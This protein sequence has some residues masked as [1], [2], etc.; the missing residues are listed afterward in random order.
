ML[1]SRDLGSSDLWLR[2]LERSRRRRV[3]AVEGRKQSTRRKGGSVAMSAAL[4][5]GPGSSILAATAVA[6]P[7]KGSKA[8]SSPRVKRAMARV[9]LEYGSSGEAVAA[10]Q[11]S[12]GIPADGIFGP[13]TQGAV[14]SFQDDND[15]RASGRVDERTWETLLDYERLE[16]YRPPA[17]K[18]ANTGAVDRSPAA[19]PVVAID[20]DTSETD[21]PK[22]S[23]RV[24]EAPPKG[25]SPAPTPER[26]DPSEKPKPS[27]EEAPKRPDADAE[28]RAD[29]EAEKRAKAEA[30]EK[31]A[32]AEAEKRDRADTPKRRD[33]ADR[34]GT[35]VEGSCGGTLAKPVSGPQTS[36]FGQR[37]GRLH[38][39]IDIAAPSGT[40]IKSAACGVV[41]QAGVA[42]GYGNMVCVRHTSTFTT[43]YAHMSRIG[44]RLGAFVRIGEVIGYVGST[45]NSTGPHLHFETRVSG[46]PRNPIAYLRG[47]QMTPGKPVQMS[48]RSGRALSV[49]GSRTTPARVTRWRKAS[50]SYAAQRSQAA[51]G[52]RA[53][54]APRST[55]PKR[56]GWTASASR[57]STYSSGTTGQSSTAPQADTS[58]EETTQTQTPVEQSSPSVSSPSG[59]G[60]GSSDGTATT[61]SSPSPAGPVVTPDA[62]AA[63]SGVD[64][65]STSDDATGGSAASGGAASSDT[66]ASTGESADAAESPASSGSS[67]SAGSSGSTES[68]T[69][70]SGS[71]GSTGS[72]ES[73]GST[74][75]TGSTGTSGST[76]S[77]ESSGSSGS[78]GATE[79]PDSTGSG[80]TGSSGAPG[81]TGPSSASTSAA[82]S[83]ATTSTGE[84]GSASGSDATSSAPGGDSS[85]AGEGATSTTP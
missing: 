38:A 43:C 51:A 73:S 52:R 30:E 56:S 49:S 79:S 84:A 28:K 81:S 47:G 9:L 4:A 80:S 74:G 11:R 61:T 24:E 31:R 39:G 48:S 34:E 42:G 5:A 36:S 16:R 50:R 60:S 18:P 26:S 20:I 66:P 29:A 78:T 27:T 17:E 13:Q 44:A 7:V 53:A 82:P 23:A 35:T 8:P 63:P 75:S 55:M 37:W 41:S 59:T 67:T 45:G 19:G 76:G 1:A 10:V 77:T 22:V 6:H 72:T 69:G 54:T 65:S 58:N 40:P 21:R 68:A 71:T 85:S 57:P 3:I 14:R 64:G 2:S 62:S 25:V 32:K 70:S 15:L 33:A 46:A 83:G 12:L